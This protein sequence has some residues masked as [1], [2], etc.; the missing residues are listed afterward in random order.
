MYSTNVVR[1]RTAFL[2][3]GPK[4]SVYSGSVQDYSKEP[5]RSFKNANLQEIFLNNCRK[6][7]NIV[8][9]ELLAGERR[10]GIIIGFDSQSIILSDNKSQNLIF[11][12]AIASVA[13]EDEVQ[14]IF[15]E[16]QKKEQINSRD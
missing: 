1:T 5:S 9:I 12:N 2:D 3:N 7:E 13:P 15:S 10:R 16:V 4:G 8:I 14:Y 6:N 11:K